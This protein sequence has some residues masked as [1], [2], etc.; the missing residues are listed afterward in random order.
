MKKIRHDKLKYRHLCLHDSMLTKINIFDDK[1]I[2]LEAERNDVKL[3]ITF[4]ELFTL[5][6]EEEL[7]VL[8][9]F[10]L[11]EDDYEHRIYKKTA[12]QNAT[13]EKVIIRFHIRYSKIIYTLIYGQ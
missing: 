12:V 5:T 9:D 4:L 3:C 8:Y 1:V 2:T 10:D 7:L 13:V 6:L 11:L